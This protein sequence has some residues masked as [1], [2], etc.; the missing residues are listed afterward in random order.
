MGIIGG[1]VVVV[2]VVDV[3]EL[4]GELSEVVVTVAVVVASVDEAGD[5][6]E[7]VSCDVLEEL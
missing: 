2:D 5:E 1:D 3:V 6:V 7:V 4:D